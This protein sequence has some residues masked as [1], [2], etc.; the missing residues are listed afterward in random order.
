MDA[1]IS[2]GAT[3]LL[4]AV[5]DGITIQNTTGRIVYANPAAARIIGFDSPAELLATPISEIMQRFEVFDEDGAPFP[6]E[7]LP[8]RAVL[9]GEPAGQRVLQFRVRGS[10]E[11]RWSVLKA[12]P[13]YNPDG[14]IRLVVNIWHDITERMERQRALEEATTQLEETTVE[15]EVTISELEARTDEA[16]TRA[17]RHKFLAEAGRMLASSFDAEETLR[18]VVHLAVPSIANWAEIRLLRE[19]GELQRLEIAHADPEKLLA[20]MQLEERFPAD[21]ATS[22]TYEVVRTGTPRIFREVPD[23]LVRKTARS[24][25]HYRLLSA[26]ELDSALIVPI[27]VRDATLGTILMAR[28]KQQRAFDDEDLEFAESFAARAGLALT[29]ARLYG[30][31][32][33]ANRTKADFLAVMSHELRTPLTAIFGY[34]ELLATG[35]AGQMTDTQ[36]AHLDRIH[37]S[38]S[39]LLTIIEDIL[40]YARTEAG[41]D[42]VHADVF[43]LSEVI[44]EALMVVRPNAE[45]KALLLEANVAEDAPL[46]TDRA[47]LRQIVINL[48]GNAIKFTDHGSV[49]VHA[50]A[51]DRECRISVEDTGVGIDPGD[52]DRIFEP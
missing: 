49:R 36:R 46:H 42:E 20:A 43:R 41:R 21:P 12:E 4:D 50:T 9:A 32:Q 2:A 23:A 30:E 18:M 6:P 28:S 44:S 52:L 15:L 7:R 8:G 33:E 22:P 3:A 11:L 47:K 14:S 29:N 5:G 27:K 10:A 13:V 19:D 24:E 26:L 37:G 38:A 17:E 45:K 39:Q 34:T 31:A 51:G 25:E 35:V 16:E 48:L 40:A 1:L